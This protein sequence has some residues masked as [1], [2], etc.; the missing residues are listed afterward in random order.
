MH[1]SVFVGRVLGW[2]T[3]IAFGLFTFLCL[4]VLS[5]TYVAS[6]YALKEYVE[7]QLDRISWDLAFYQLKEIPREQEIRNSLMGLPHVLEAQSLV[8]LRTRMPP[9]MRAEAGGE[10]V[11]MPWFIVLATTDPGL[12]P[13]EYRVEGD[14]T[15]LALFGAKQA[16]Q[17]NLDRLQGARSFAFLG[18]QNQEEEHLDDHDHAE[19]P[20]TYRELMNFPISQIVQLDREELNRWFLEHTG[21]IAF[22]PFMGAALNTRYDPALISRL[23]SLFHA[24]VHEHEELDIHAESGDYLPEVS[25]VARI[26]RGELISG[27]DLDGSHERIAA[28]VSQAS[29]LLPDTAQIYVRSDTLILLDRMRKTADLIGWVAL[30]L[31]LPII[32]MAWVFAANLVHFVF[33]NERRTIGLMRLRGLSGAILVRIFLVAILMGGL[34]GGLLGLA[35]GTVVPLAVYEG[36]GSV[37]ELIQLQ[38]PLMALSFLAFALVIAGIIGGRLVK[39]VRRL[40]PGEASKRFSTVPEAALSFGVLPGIALVLGAYKVAAWSLGWSVGDTL[41]DLQEADRL[42]DFVAVPLLIYG[43]GVLMASRRTLIAVAIRSVA[44]LSV[45]RLKQFAVEQGSHKPA[46]VAGVFLVGSLASAIVLAPSIASHSFTDK[47]V[48]GV[49]IQMGADAQL[50]FNTLD[51]AGQPQEH[52]GPEVERL[53]EP[54]TDVL[55]DLRNNPNIAAALGLIKTM[56]PLYMPGYGYGGVPAFLLNAPLEYRENAYWEE[57]LGVDQPFSQILQRIQEGAVAVSPAVAEFWGVEAGDSIL[58]GIDESGQAIVAEVAGIVAAL[59]GAPRRAVGDRDSFVAALTDYLN[60][61]FAEE[62]F[63]VSSTNQESIQQLS[64]LVPQMVALVQSN[65]GAD[66][67]SFDELALPVRGVNAL[68]VELDR[69]Q[70]DMFIYLVGENLKIYLIAGFLV[71]LA[72]VMAIFLVNYWEARRTFSLL[73]VRGASPKDL[74]GALSVQLYAPLVWSLLLGGV[75][76]IVSGYGIAQRIWDLQRVLT[77]INQLPTHLILT[78]YDALL[79]ISILGLM[80]TLVIGLGFWTFRRTAREA[81]IHE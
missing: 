40:T 50:L 18:R 64:A 7:D 46:R 24:Q 36:L 78:G 69:V 30:L 39:A 60:F 49:R 51:V 16:I 12:L 59:P 56:I 34:I 22:V 55:N 52:L 47:A 5:A 8:F 72:A 75:V 32:G 53:R 38:R 26:N 29:E 27:W 79:V 58:L 42:L 33:L 6:R 23:D 54:F 65:Q 17:F 3:C 20:D 43:L 13:P 21:A 74:I 76:G 81:I 57:S 71:A 44:F 15:V 70:Q 48:R 80:F 73:R 28:L 25:H 67:P 66:L 41:Q 63:V 68:S 77:V 1:K 11:V 19:A 4:A 45:G 61:L 62:A 14:R 31:A 9:G 2:R 35:L 37:W 10:P